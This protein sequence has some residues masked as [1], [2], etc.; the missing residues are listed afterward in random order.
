VGYA[1]A[2]ALDDTGVVCWGDNLNGATTV[3]A[4]THP[5]AVYAGSGYSCA[6][7]H[8]PSGEQVVCWGFNGDGQTTVPAL[9]SP[10]KVSAGGHHVCALNQDTVVCWG[11]NSSG[12]TTIPTLNRPI[13]ISAGGLHTCVIDQTSSGKQV[14]CWGAGT[15]NT[16][17]GNELGQSIV[18][19]LHHPVAVSAGELDTCALD[20]TGVVCWGNDPYGQTDVPAV[21]HFDRDSDGLDDSVEDSNHNGRVDAGETNPLEADSDGDGL[22]DGTEDSNGNGVVDAGETDPL[23]SD[24]DGDGLSDGFE[25]NVAGTDPAVS[26]PVIADPADMNSDGQ[27]NAADILLIERT[28]LHQVP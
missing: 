22:S 15:T 11:S 14:V 26:T 18:P 17:I 4:L 21:L 16:G 1:H 6:L 25:V 27:L 20:D 9:P 13:A 12:Q 7:D 19:V 5:V 24:S 28:V 2:C 23:N 10:N 8:T 3:P